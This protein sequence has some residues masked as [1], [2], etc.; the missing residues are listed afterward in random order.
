MNL[1]LVQEDLSEYANSYNKKT[2]VA[3]PNSMD[4]P[5]ED[6]KEESPARSLRSSSFNSS[7]LMEFAKMGSDDMGRERACS[8]I[9]TNSQLSIRKDPNKEFF[10]MLLLAYKMNNQETDEVLMLDGRDLYNKCTQEDKT[11]FHKFPEWITKEIKRIHFKK[12]YMENKK[13]LERNKRLLNKI[14]AMDGKLL[15]PQI[16]IVENYFDF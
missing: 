1:T 2:F 8:M 6:K 9:S 7:T 10:Q 4:I 16:K 14:E 3:S 15:V 5:D 13:R 11:P 12:I